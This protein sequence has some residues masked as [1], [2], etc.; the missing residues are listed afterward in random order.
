MSIEPVIPSTIQ[1][2]PV[3]GLAQLALECAESNRRPMLRVFVTF[4]PEASN[5]RRAT[6]RVVNR[7]G[8]PCTGVFLVAMA[9]GLAEDGAPGGTQTLTVAKGHAFGGGISNQSAILLTHPD[10]SAEVD[11][12]VT[13]A[14][15][16]HVRA[17]VIGT[18]SSASTT[19]A[20]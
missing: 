8:E 13:G 18:G 12:A 10:G 3:R 15:T 5:T 1:E 9:V 17:W 20:A 7:R 19:W 4:G 14:A 16:R 11:I 6:L 2:Q